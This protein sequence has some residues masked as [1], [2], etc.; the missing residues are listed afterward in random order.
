MTKRYG[1][2]VAILAA[3]GLLECV[4][5]PVVAALQ[6]EGS[7]FLFPLYYF[8]RLFALGAPFF[9][10]G[11]VFSAWRRYA[12]GRIWLLFL[13]F[14]VIDLI[15]Q[16]PISLFAYYNDLL[17]SFGLLFGGYALS[18][19]ASSLLVLLLAL[20]G[21][22]LFFFKKEESTATFA[23]FTVKSKEGKASALCAA[24]FTL[25]LLITETIQI[26]ED[27]SARLWIV[28]GIDLLNYLFSLVFVAVC[29]LGCYVAA[30]AG[31]LLI[32]E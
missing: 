29:G 17:S 26:V 25:Y 23:F 27:A 4:L 9:T 2:F 16:V 28:D 31:S 11:A 30:R 13:P 18:S 12:F 20:L 24:A 7:A 21:Y 15:A 10:L 19:L 22:F 14:L 8:S 6:E 5:T 1:L 32:K 3:A